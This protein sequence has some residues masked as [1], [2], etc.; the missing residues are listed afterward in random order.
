M[1]CLTWMGKPK[2]AHGSCWWQENWSVWQ[3]FVTTWLYLENCQSHW[4]PYNKAAYT[5]TLW[6]LSSKW[7]SFSCSIQAVRPQ[8]CTVKLDLRAIEEKMQC[9]TSPMAYQPH[10][11]STSTST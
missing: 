9:V 10:L 2:V 6:L 5:I 1:V 3:I 4:N 11:L 7:M 8:W